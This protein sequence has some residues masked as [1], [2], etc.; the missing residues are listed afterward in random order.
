MSCASGT[1]SAIIGGPFYYGA[2]VELDLKD[3]STAE[4]RIASST[5]E[6]NLSI[7]LVDAD[8]MGGKIHLDINPLSQTV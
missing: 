3:G 6:Y 7:K 2:G 8:S 1:Q 4:T 5:Y